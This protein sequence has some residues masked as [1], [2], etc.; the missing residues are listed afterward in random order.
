MT[1]FGL[2]G[3]LSLIPT[4]YSSIAYSHMIPS[5]FGTIIKYA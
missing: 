5:Y 3:M 4:L 2:L 1:L